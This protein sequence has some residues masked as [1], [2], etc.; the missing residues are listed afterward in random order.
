MDVQ[1]QEI[2]YYTLH[3]QTTDKSSL[4]AVYTPDGK[5]VRSR[6]EVK[7][8]EPPK[9]ILDNLGKS[10]YKDWKITK[11][12]HVIKVYEGKTSKDHYALSLQ[13]GKQKKVVY[14][15]KDGNML[16]NRKKS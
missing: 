9:A 2:N 5:L 7:N 16:M 10:N 15:D 6:E 3:T 12:V 13:K 4:D 8:F 11:D 1:K 14:F